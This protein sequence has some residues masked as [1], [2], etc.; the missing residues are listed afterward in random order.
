MT[1][2]LEEA[3]KAIDQLTAEKAEALTEIARFKEA[4]VLAKAADVV[5][6]ALAKQDIPEMTKARLVES[7]AKNPPI[8]DGE[9]DEDAFK[10]AIEEAVKAEMAY[11]TELAGAGA[12]RG[13]GGTPADSE[14]DKDALKESWIALYRNKGETLEKAT[15]LAERAMEG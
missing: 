4:A 15:L 11:L 10:A 1:E 13:M 8:K 7:I 5:S 2:K 14:A 6:E 12:I 9:L 3:Q